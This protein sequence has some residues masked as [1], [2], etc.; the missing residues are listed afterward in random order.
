MREVPLV[1]GLFALLVTPAAAAVLYV[2]GKYPTIQQALNAAGSGDTILVAPGI[3]KENLTWPSI[4][5]IRLIGV[6]GWAG[7]TI[8]GARNGRVVVF[9][10]GLTRATVFE[11]FTVTGGYMNTPHNYGCGILVQDS[12]PTIRGNLITGNVG[13]GI[14][15]SHGGGIGVFGSSRPLIERNIIAKNILKN[16]FW[17][18]GAGIYVEWMASPD[19][20]A[21]QIFQNENRGG[22]WGFGGGIYVGS[23]VS[24]T[25]VVGNVIAG[26]L[27]SGGG[28]S[29]GGGIHV[30]SSAAANL[31]NNTIVGNV[32]NYSSCKCGGGIEYSGTAAGAIRNNIVVGNT[33]TAG[34]GIMVSGTVPPCDFNNVW[35]NAGG[36]YSGLAPSP[37]S[38]SADPLF[39]GAQDYHLTYRSPCIDAG[40][41]AALGTLAL[42]DHDGDSRRLDGNLDGLKGDGAA[43]DIGADEYALA[44]VTIS[45]PAR[46]GTTVTLDVSGP[47]GASWALAWSP[48]TGGLFV[49]PYGYVL[50][51]VPFGLLGSGVAPGKVPLPLPAVPV[52]IGM[53]V[54]VQGVLGLVHGGQGVGNV[55]G[56]LDITLF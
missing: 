32:C 15:W 38:I 16:G 33:A 34:G 39:A 40:S 55:T 47:V 29:F 3:Y 4:D 31:V 54:H 46:L 35:N 23:Y 6:A 50:I 28:W 51:G 45:G 49:D 52:L 9:G 48:W 13:D 30:A 42:Q 21:N 25:K 26:N 36:D 44:R 19:I 10:S 22:Q 2:P 27:C 7:T 11:G 53:T 24:S 18:H 43:P 37:T 5:G 56:R 14:S 8:D 17:N 41:Q 1:L 12:S 20:V